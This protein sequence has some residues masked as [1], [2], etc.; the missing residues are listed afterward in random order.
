MIYP[1]STRMEFTK[2]KTVD[3]FIRIHDASQN[4]ADRENKTVINLMAV[5]QSKSHHR[6][7][8]FMYN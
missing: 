8:C 5:T 1:V 3:N 6:H 2:H 7:V 4:E